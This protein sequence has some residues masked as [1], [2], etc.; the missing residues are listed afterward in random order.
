MNPVL[1]YFNAERFYCGIGI[2]IGGIALLLALYFWL[3][4][5]QPFYVG[6]AYPLVIVGTF[7]LII[8][9]GVF[10]RSPRDIARVQHAIGN[11]RSHIK[12][13]ELPRM[14]GV[15]K[16]FRVIMVVEVVLVAVS[17]LL[18]LFAPLSPAWKGAMSGLLALAASLLAFDWLAAQRGQVYL[19]FLKGL[20]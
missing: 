6:M 8:C 18:L 15:M 20:V 4:V 3:K 2:T 10:F 16:T 7:F 13:V 12:S 9:T 14:D 19:D 1:K 11:D 5:K 17:A